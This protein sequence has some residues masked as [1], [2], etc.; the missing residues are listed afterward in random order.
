MW[1]AREQKR[2]RKTFHTLTEAKAWRA[3]ALVGLRRGTMRARTTTTLRE[4]WNAWIFGARDGT[5]RNRS[6]DAYKPS[7]LRGYETSM[8]LRVLPELGGARLSD[9]T[10]V[11]VQEFADRML[12]DELDPSTIR[13]TLVPLRAIFRRSLARGEVAL[14]PVAGVELPSVRGTRDRIASPAE[15]VALIE[16]VPEDDRAV[17]AMAFYAGLRLGELWA[18]RDEDV[19]L[20]AGVIRVERSWDRKAGVIEPKSRASRRVVPIVAALRS[21]LAARKLRRRRSSALFFGEG[22]TPFNRDGLVARAEKAWKKAGVEPIGLHEARHTF[23]SILIAAG[24]NAKALSTYLGHA[25]IQITLDRYGHLMPGNEDEAVA[26]VDA[27]LERATV[28]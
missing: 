19:D 24:V 26:L 28:V 18:L 5:V 15:A 22:T 4:A 23:A 7:A 1:S 10:R 16:A 20:E 17:W 14:N 12:A 3:E 13:N 27:Y 11:S 9:V 6:G 2:I 8:R 25:S 21:H